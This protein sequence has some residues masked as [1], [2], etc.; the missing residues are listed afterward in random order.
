MML[1][2]V[3]VGYA[4]GVPRQMTGNGGMCIIKGCKVPIVGRI[5]MDMI[6]LDVTAVDS[7]AP[8]DIVTVIGGD[9]DSEIRCEDV[10]A[11]ADTITNDILCRLGSRLQKVYVENK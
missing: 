11:A 5:C 3:G 10:A 1:A 6:M 9:G 8:G 2:T 7:V 4:D